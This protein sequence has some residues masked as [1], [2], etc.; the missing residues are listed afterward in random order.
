MPSKQTLSWSPTI[1]ASGLSPDSKLRI[2]RRYLEDNLSLEAKGEV[3]RR[4]AEVKGALGKGAGT[5][6]RAMY[7]R[8]LVYAEPVRA[9]LSRSNVKRRESAQKTAMIAKML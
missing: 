1:E 7:H 9:H 4:K 5:S 3:R 2:G 6:L 8:R